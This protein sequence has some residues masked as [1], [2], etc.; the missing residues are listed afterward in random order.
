MS[1]YLVAGFE[2]SWHHLRII[3]G[4]GFC[5]VVIEVLDGTEPRSFS[6]IEREFSFSGSL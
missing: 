1:K 3:P 6:E 2:A 5:D 4:L